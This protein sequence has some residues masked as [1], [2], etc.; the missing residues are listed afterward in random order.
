MTEVTPKSIFRVI[1]C[2]LGSGDPEMLDYEER[3]GPDRMRDIPRDQTSR[4]ASATEVQLYQVKPEAEAVPSRNA[5]YQDAVG[6]PP[7]P[8]ADLRK[9]EE[10]NSLEMFLRVRK[11]DRYAP[12]LSQIGAKTISDLAFL[13]PQDLET[14]GIQPDDI[15]NLTIKFVQ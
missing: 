10:E 11:M 13:T 15:N 6:A 5:T 9:S 3:E 14:I 12:A 1:A 4:Q 8:T 2:G 7:F